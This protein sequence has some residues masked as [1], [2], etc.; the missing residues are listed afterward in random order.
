MSFLKATTTL[1][2]WWNQFPSKLRRITTCRLLASIG[3][4]G[5]L[6]LTPLVFNNLSF[7]ATQIGLGFCAAAAAGT[8]TRLTT[9]IFLDRG[10]GFSIPLRIAALLAITADLILFTAYTKQA[11]IFGELFLG[12]AAGI[13]WPS[14][15]I[16]IP[17]SCK[18]GQSGKGF[19]LARTAD[20]LG[21]SIGVLLGSVSA[22]IG[23]LRS[24][25]LIEICCMFILLALLEDKD[26]KQILPV[27]RVNPN[28]NSSNMIIK[29]YSEIINLI[30]T[31][32]PMLVLSILSTGIL[33]LMQIGL[34]LDLVKGGINR[35]GIESNLIGWVIAYKLILLLLLQWPIGKWLSKKNIKYGL[36]LSTINFMVGCLLLSLSS[37]YYN[38]LILMIVGL[39]PISIG[40][41]MFLPTATES[42]VQISPKSF[43][44]LSM[45]IYSQCFGIS[46]LV[47]P[48]IAGRI[49]DETGD[50]MILWLATSIC[51]LLVYPLINKI[52]L[53]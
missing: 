31:L 29:N 6:Y 25:Y 7:S 15:E 20:A 24:I 17:I 12:G 2:Q 8:F 13:Y 4:G 43:R 23:Y 47:F 14:V 53:A 16:A 44:G 22:S 39:V 28:I 50:G 35:P 52:K 49:I 41:A 34:Q 3:A 45:A 5:V 27:S 10:T 30:K 48:L 19:A 51:C 11:Y 38:G 18:E 46:F 32:S 40:I 26:S 9:G 21:V 33:S 37:F 1:K 42:I 36:R